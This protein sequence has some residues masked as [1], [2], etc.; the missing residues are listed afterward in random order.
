MKSVFEPSFRDW[1]GAKDKV[2]REKLQPLLQKLQADHP[3]WT[4]SKSELPSGVSAVEFFQALEGSGS[5]MSN[6]Y[7]DSFAT[8]DLFPHE[9]ILGSGSPFFIQRSRGVDGDPGQEAINLIYC[10]EWSANSVGAGAG[11]AAMTLLD[12]VMGGLALYHTKT[13]CPTKSMKFEFL[14][15][16]NSIPGA[17]IAKAKVVNIVKKS[18]LYLE[19]VL[20]DV[21]GKELTR[22][23]GVFAVRPTEGGQIRKSKL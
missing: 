4:F 15:P 18:E 7:F 21:N 8:R 20:T 19:G 9:Y 2:A 22:A 10:Y 5:S 16:M 17:Y 11:G 13:H 6:L 3:E 1:I 12:D 14:R 23:N